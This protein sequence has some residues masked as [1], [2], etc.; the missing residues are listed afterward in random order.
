MEKINKIIDDFLKNFSENKRKEAEI[1]SIFYEILP[2]KHKDYL[3]V[4][5]VRDGIVF[6]KTSSPFIKNEISFIKNEII[7]KINEKIGGNFI[8]DIKIRRGK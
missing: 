2:L 3:K 4:E 7:K 6:L 5:D 1:F 8:K